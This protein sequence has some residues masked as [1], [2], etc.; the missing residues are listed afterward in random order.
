MWEEE[1]R[2]LWLLLSHGQRRWQGRDGA[3]TMA[4]LTRARGHRDLCFP[5]KKLAA[6]CPGSFGEGHE[7]L[8]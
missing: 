8:A 4:W 1:R 5:V 6:W 2:A 3:G 7:A